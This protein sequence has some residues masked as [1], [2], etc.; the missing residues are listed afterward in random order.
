[1][2]KHTP[3]PWRLDGP[4]LIV[5]DTRDIAKAYQHEEGQANARLIAAAPD[6]YAC[7]RNLYERGLI[8]GTDT[9]VLDEVKDALFKADEDFDPY[10]EEQ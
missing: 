6:L 1:M 4:A 8:G 7:L 5:T 9:D 3:G 2:S 10:E